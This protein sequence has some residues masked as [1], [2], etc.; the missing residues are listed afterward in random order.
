MNNNNKLNKNRQ[1]LTDFTLRP[2][3]CVIMTTAMSPTMTFAEDNIDLEEVIV[4]GSATGRS[5]LE[6]SLSVTT[7][8]QERIENSVARNTT[9]IFR[10]IPGVRA[11]SS[12][13][14]SNTNIS[15]RGI[16]VAS[17]GG[18]F[19]QL[20][21]D[22]LPVLQFGDIIVGN[23][24]NYIVYDNTVARIEA[25][26]GGSAATLAS[27][28]P[29][30]IINFISKTGE[31]EGGS[32]TYTK[33]LD[34]DSDRLD[35]EYGTPFGDGWAVH[36]G[37]YYRD[38]EG[39]RETGFNGNRGGQIKLSLK[40]N[41][42]AG[43]ARVYYKNL[44]DRT[45]TYL[46]MPL[47]A[48]GSS[49]PGFDAK[50]ASNIPSELLANRTGDG[51]TSIRNSS[52]GD[53]SKVKS[54]VLGGEL[55]LNLSDS[56]VLSERIRVAQNSGKF[57]G[58]FT[59]GLGSATDVA[60]ISGPL[61][62]ADG[63]AY[64]SGPNA[65]NL[66]TNAELA[67]LNGNG[68]IQNIRTF[69]NDIESLDNFS[70]DIRLTKSFDF[71]D[72]TLGYYTATQDIN[73][74]WY[75]QTY[76]ADVSDDVR[77]LDA[78]T[79]NQQLTYGGL[80]AYGAPDWGFCC[81]RDTELQT[82]LD[83]VYIAADLNITERFSVSASVRHDEGEGVGH[84]AFGEN[85][86]VDFDSDGVISLAESQA[87][88][89]S[90]R[91]IAQS[92]YSYDWDYTSYALG[93]NLIL[94]DRMAIFANISEG[95]RA[96]ADRL[97]DGG[98]IVNGEVVD[99]AVENTV[100][101]YEMGIKHESDNFGIFAT[102]FFVETEDVNSE[103][104]NGTTNTARVREYESQGLE[105]ELVGSI[106]NL[107]LF[108]STTW[109]DAEITASNDSSLVG[110]TPRR[111]ADIVYSGNAAY[112]FQDVHSVG[113]SMVG[114]TDSFA[115]DANDY[116]LDGYTYLN[117]FVN[118]EIAEGFTA[119]LDVNNLTDEIGITEA[120]ENTPVTIN[121]QDYIRGRSIAGRSTT[122]SLR[123]RF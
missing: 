90:Q 62:S 110:N 84:Y 3:A 49:V 1:S 114:T 44:N 18:K 26:K 29:A 96:N 88:V 70:N 2:L 103:G 73:V 8:N 80:V 104:T 86:S 112:Y 100:N 28:S 117:A 65:G 55:V 72:F 118:I 35:F 83:A 76:L 116:E 64:A 47:R 79:G 89:I 120:E 85:Q 40:K 48:D 69:D 41:F 121:G 93:A 78:Y 119:R 15:I 10:S 98:F 46:P 25:V 24:D 4:T 87:Q 38:G 75:W 111:Q 71:G 108:G 99:G 20:H 59:A 39:V 53:G 92:H 33:G 115:Q 57:F 30:G 19:L 36:V 27:N 61:A 107:Q 23:A 34:F 81:Y 67:N 94:T 9:E 50:T 52:I 54:N 77:L 22:G 101:Q 42:D 60:S 7:V 43:H 13:G 12:A 32:F 17:G 68:L 63:L 123:Y 58:A 102:A 105:L 5:K 91:A 45:S 106:G 11:E 14:E 16:P 56:L 51:G 37:G 97:G 82:D 66:L 74:N 6:T 113:L 109:T 122:L 95:G 21:E 31:E